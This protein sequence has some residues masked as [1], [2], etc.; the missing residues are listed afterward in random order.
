MLQ[1]CTYGFTPAAQR[2]AID[3]QANDDI[4][5]LGRAGK[6]NRLTHE[7]CDPGP[8]REVLALD[9]LRVA[10]ARLVRIRSEMTRVRAPRVRRILR[11][12]KRFQQAFEFQKHL[13][14]ATPKDV[15]QDLTAAVINRVPEPPRLS[16]PT[17]VGPPLID[18]R[19]GSPLDHHVHLVRMQHVEQ[20]SGH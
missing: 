15:G 11:N 3:K 2:I 10:L 19:F 16:F 7:A 18:F 1:I 9:L 14:F 8:Q 13:I 17:Y 4:R 20:R 6:A 12:A 5:H